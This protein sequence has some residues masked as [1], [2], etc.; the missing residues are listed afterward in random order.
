MKGADGRKNATLL[1]AGAACVL[2]AGATLVAGNWPSFRGDSAGGVGTGTPPVTW[3][4][5]KGTNIAWNTAVPGLGQSSPVVWG[6]RIFLTTAVPLSG[7]AAPP[8]TGIMEVVGTALADD[9]GEHEWRVYA[10]DRGTGRVVWQQVARKG[11]PRS[12]HHRKSSHASA[13]P[14]TDGKYVVALMASEGLFCYDVD[15]K[16]LWKKDLAMD[17]GQAGAP[18]VQWGP[19][20]SPVIAGDRVIVQN[21]EQ[22]DSYLA[23]FDLATGKQLWRSGREELP[24]WSTPLIAHSVKALEGKSVEDNPKVGPHL[25][26]SLQLDL[27]LL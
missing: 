14:A 16:L 13:T 4:L 15:G 10:F 21:D 8:V 23:A 6:D 19:G 24:S 22:V 7:K 3:D 12:K 17:L 20:S 26:D 11:R 2:F 27:I 9:T 18:E 1:L 5:V 25:A